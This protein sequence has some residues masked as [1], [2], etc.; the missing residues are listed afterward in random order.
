MGFFKKEVKK[1]K[2]PQNSRN[3]QTNNQ[4]FSD[5]P[6]QLPKLP[7][8]PPMQPSQSQEQ[9]DQENFQ[10]SQIPSPSL[11]VFP[12]SQ[13][14]N[15]MNQ[16]SIKDAVYQEEMES[17]IPTPP[18]KMKRIT[19]PSERNIP[20]RQ[21]PPP[22]QQPHQYHEEPEEQIY[23]EREPHTMEMSNQ[24]FSQ[25]PR[26]TRRTEPLFIQLDKF[27]K[28]ISIFDEI[29]LKI[30]E[31]ES[32]LSSIKEV[33]TKEDEKINHWTNEIESIKS[34]LDDIDKNIFG[35]I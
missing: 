34:Q 17:S 21:S 19:P 1:K 6:P 28:T 5:A 16:N 10:D 3:T 32:L 27:E 23:A 26:R 15:Q 7:S 30:S 33:K 31:M 8:V 4:E 29:K 9:I 35:Q 22:I 2:N 11:P 14:G 20:L 25:T 24:N 12:N 18:Q 13:M